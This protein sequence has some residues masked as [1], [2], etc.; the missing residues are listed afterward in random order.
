MSVGFQMDDR[1]PLATRE[2]ILAKHV[3]EASLCRLPKGKQFLHRGLKTAKDAAS[4]IRDE[5]QICR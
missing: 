5:I 2:S 3:S 4:K 1:D